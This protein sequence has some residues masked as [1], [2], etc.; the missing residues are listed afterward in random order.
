MSVSSVPKGYMLS[1]MPHRH[2]CLPSS[3]ASPSA[4]HPMQCKVGHEIWLKQSR[5]TPFYNFQGLKQHV[6]DLL[7]Q[8]WFLPLPLPLLLG[9]CCVACLLQ[10]IL[11]PAQLF[12]R[13]V[14]S[15]R[16]CWDFNCYQEIPLFISIEISNINKSSS[17]IRCH[18]AWITSCFKRAKAETWIHALHPHLQLLN[19]NT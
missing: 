17:S 6:L 19:H 9:T 1:Q 14:A 11:L 10:L 7:A 5:T 2:A 8:L 4:Q 15:R 16:I 13:C 12:Q 3:L 18:A